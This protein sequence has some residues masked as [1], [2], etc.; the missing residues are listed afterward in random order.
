MAIS[1]K[2]LSTDDQAFMERL[3]M[4]YQRLIY[5]VARRTCVNPNLWDDIVQESVLRLCRFAHRLRPLPERELAAYISV[6]ARHTTIEF[7]REEA[8]R[9]EH[10]VDWED[11]E[12]IMLDRGPTPE[13]FLEL[14]E[15]KVRLREVWSDMTA[16]EQWVLYA[17]YL[18]LPDKEQ[19]ERLGCQADTVRVKRSRAR[20]KALRLMLEAEGGDT[21]GGSGRKET[22]RAKGD[23]TLGAV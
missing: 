1:F 7:I 18:G 13:E 11:A 12:Q 22:D 19:A 8:V 2:P 9:Q 5:A 21:S 15:R 23:P 10:T 20:R 4:T 14:M 17:W 3:F 16:E 6:T